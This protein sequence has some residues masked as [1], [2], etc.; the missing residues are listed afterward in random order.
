ML[1][2]PQNHMFFS[3]NYHVAQKLEQLE[4]NRKKHLKVHS[5]GYQHL[6]IGFELKSVF[7]VI[8]SKKAFYVKI[9]FNSFIVG[10]NA[11]KILQLHAIL[12]LY[13]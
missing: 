5:T 10:T 2:F 13:K 12:P 6:P 7:K 8:K 3:R 4:E 11:K 9:V 1:N